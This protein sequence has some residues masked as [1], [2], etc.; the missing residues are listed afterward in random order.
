MLHNVVLYD[1]VFLWIVPYKIKG[2]NDVAK[3][4]NYEGPLSKD[5]Y[6]FLDSLGIQC[7]LDKEKHIKADSA[8]IYNQIKQVINSQKV[9]IQESLYIIIFKIRKYW[10][11]LK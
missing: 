8:T 10:S 4:L 6:M 9:S 5:D 3:N 1:I 11:E 2:V 7:F